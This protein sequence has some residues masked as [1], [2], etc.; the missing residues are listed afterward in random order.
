[1]S[2]EPKK[3]DD[4]FVLPDWWPTEEELLASLNEPPTPNDKSE[5]T[6]IVPSPRPKSITPEEAA[7]RVHHEE[8]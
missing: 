4:D 6:I 8:A 5:V 7:P 3:V 2:K 1:M